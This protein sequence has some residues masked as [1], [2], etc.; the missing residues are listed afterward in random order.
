MALVLDTRFLITHTFP[1]TKKDRDKIRFFIAKIRRE[2]L[3]M[4]SVVVVEY[5]KVTDRGSAAK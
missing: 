1:P 2:K 4:P 3:Y 5:I